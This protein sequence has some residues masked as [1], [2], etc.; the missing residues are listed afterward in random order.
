MILSDYFFYSGINAGTY[1]ERIP[2]T[3]PY[4]VSIMSP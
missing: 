1:I 3:S 2:N 4:K